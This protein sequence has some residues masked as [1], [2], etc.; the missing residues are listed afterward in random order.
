MGT[1]GLTNRK[2][3]PV[4]YTVVGPLSRIKGNLLRTNPVSD[5]D[6]SN[7]GGDDDDDR[8]VLCCALSVPVHLQRAESWSE[9]TSHIIPV[10]QRRKL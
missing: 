9:F 6:D 7:N 8:R 10:P 5:D 2:V 4:I 1:T 3:T